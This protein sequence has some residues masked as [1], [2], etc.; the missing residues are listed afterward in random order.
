MILG[1]NFSRKMRR[2]ARSCLV[3]CTLFFLMRNTV[4]KLSKTVED[5][6]DFESWTAV[7]PGESSAVQKTFVDPYRFNWTLLER[8]FCTANK[9]PTRYLIVMYTAINGFKRR[10]A[11]R[12]MYG[13]LY[14]QK[15]GVRLLFILGASRN[16]SVEKLVRKESLLYHDIIKQDFL[17][18]YYNVPW[19]VRYISR[20]EYPNDY[21]NDYCAGLTI[22]IPVQL[23]KKMFEASKN[24][25]YIKFGDY[26]L[27]G[28]LATKVGVRFKDFSTKAFNHKFKRNRS[29]FLHK[30]IYFQ[31]TETIEQA[32]EMW[33]ELRYKYSSV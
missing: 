13:D 18:T 4:V 7:P 6:R 25:T 26:F 5:L 22:I 10:E 21:Y 14:L 9:V 17:D 29:A 19:K 16:Y 32:E 30:R 12:R 3:A 11:Y 27:T 28:V 31:A 33:N 8:D 2:F 24:A 20:A 23:V 15:L 1:L